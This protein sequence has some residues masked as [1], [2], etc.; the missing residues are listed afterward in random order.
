MATK[1]TQMPKRSPVGHGATKKSLP[2]PKISLDDVMRHPQRPATR[3]G[4]PKATPGGDGGKLH[5]KSFPP[6]K[7]ARTPTRVRKGS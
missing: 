6:Q 1:K 2:L 7:A 3:G 5:R 4:A